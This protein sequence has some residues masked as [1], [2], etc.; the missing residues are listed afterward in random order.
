MQTLTEDVVSLFREHLT[1]FRVELKRDTAIAARYAFALAFFAIISLLGFA[2][3]NLAAILF[4]G[5]AF[6]LLGM[7][8]S[9]SVLCGIHLGFGLRAFAIVARRIQEDELGPRLAG[10]ELER[11]RQWATKQVPNSQHTS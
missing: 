4:A 7:A 5:W 6:G 2:L 8:V 10:N 9:A 1:L 11:S 3:L